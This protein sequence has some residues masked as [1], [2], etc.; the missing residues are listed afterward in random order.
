MLLWFQNKKD[1]S[2]CSFGLCALLTSFG[3]IF[4]RVVFFFLQIAELN[5]KHRQPK[6]FSQTQQLLGCMK[7]RALITD[8]DESSSSSG[9]TR[10]KLINSFSFNYPH[11]DGNFQLPLCITNYNKS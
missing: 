3:E 11:K 5:L 9:E 8:H 4:E 7:A 6:Y 1:F 10:E 2:E